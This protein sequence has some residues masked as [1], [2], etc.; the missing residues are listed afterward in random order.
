[1]AKENKGVS[2]LGLNKSFIQ[3]KGV[4]MWDNSQPEIFTSFKGRPSDVWV[5]SFPRSGTTLVQ[6]IV[7]LVETLDFDGAITKPLDER[8]PFADV[9]NEDLPFYKGLT[10]LKEAKIP[11]LIKTHFHYFLLPEDLKR[12]CGKIINVYRNPKAVVVSLFKLLKFLRTPMA[13]TLEEFIEMF[14]N[15]KVYGSPWA[16]HVRE[17]QEHKN[18]ENVLILKYEDIIKDKVSEVRKIASF[19]NR[20]LSADDIA[21]IVEYVDIENMRKNGM[22]N[23]AVQEEVW[24]TDKSAGAFINSGK[25]E[26][27][28]DVIAPYLQLKIDNM[29]EKSLDA[30]N[31]NFD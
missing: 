31:I 16:A 3:F 26:S 22:V 23:F 24:S 4:W 6:E 14:V 20:D 7:Y 21:K 18:D 11:R 1:M 19:L 15:D 13:D 27:W 12:G 28:R 5:C 30:L 29:I 8:F 2:A 10:G 25:A 9:Y 17:F